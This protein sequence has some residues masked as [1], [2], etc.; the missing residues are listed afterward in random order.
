MHGACYLQTQ[1]EII[2]GSRSYSAK[3]GGTLFWR[4]FGVISLFCF[5]L[6]MAY[7]TIAYHV[8]LIGRVNA[9]EIFCGTFER[10]MLVIARVGGHWAG[11]GVMGVIAKWKGSGCLIGLWNWGWWGSAWGCGFVGEGETVCVCWC[12]SVWG[13]D[14]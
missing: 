10:R 5:I 9:S 8:N 11:K 2:K 13:M 12:V 4:E 14:G 7:K 1:I 3:L 6:C